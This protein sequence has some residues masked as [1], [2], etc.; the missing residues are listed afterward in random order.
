MG[1]FNIF[2]GVGKFNIGGGDQ[3]RLSLSPIHLQTQNPEPYEPQSKL[4][5]GAYMGDYI[6]DYYRGYSGGYKEFRLWF[7]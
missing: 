4:L 5:K 2:C 1:V 7:I 3:L 6:R